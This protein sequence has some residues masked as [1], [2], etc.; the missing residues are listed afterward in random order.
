M[1]EVEKKF[2]YLLESMR[3]SCTK[4]ILY[5]SIDKEETDRIISKFLDSEH[6]Y[7]S[8]GMIFIN[9]E[10]IDIDCWSDVRMK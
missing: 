5:E 10:K 7:E 4:E 2:F 8:D 9:Y 3:D 1:S 6:I